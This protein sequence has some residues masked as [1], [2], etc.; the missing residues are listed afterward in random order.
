MFI[1]DTRVVANVNIWIIQLTFVIPYTM[2]V[3]KCFTA[4][5]LC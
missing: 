4:G 1:S 2:C 3:A 5:N